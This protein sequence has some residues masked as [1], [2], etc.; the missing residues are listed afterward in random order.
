MQMKS[1][2]LHLLTKKSCL[3][4]ILQ[5]LLIARLAAS[6]GTG[7]PD[8]FFSPNYKQWD[9]KVWN[10]AVAQF[11]TPTIL[12]RINPQSSTLSGVSEEELKVAL[13]KVKK[14]YRIQA[15]KLHPDREKA[16]DQDIDGQKFRLLTQ[17]FTIIKKVVGK[18]KVSENVDN[19]SQS[20]ECDPLLEKIITEENLYMLREL[21]E[22]GYL[23]LDSHATNPRLV[24]LFVKHL[25]TITWRITGREARCALEEQRKVTENSTQQVGMVSQDHVS[26]IDKL[27]E[28]AKKKNGKIDCRQGSGKI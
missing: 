4:L 10:Y 23:I 3:F 11:E 22:K 19:S 17:A 14:D 8:G 16:L 24:A 20:G 2:N 12:K 18:S 6:D 5:V 27:L 7:P 1:S 28:Q 26:F 21:I 25:M 9:T 13:R 15:L